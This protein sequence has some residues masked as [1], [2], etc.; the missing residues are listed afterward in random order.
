MLKTVHL[1]PELSLH[2][3]KMLKK[4]SKEEWDK[5]TCLPGRTV[6][7]LA[8]H[9][10]DASNL[11]RLSMQRDNYFGENPQINSYSDLVSFIQKL[12]NEWII[13]TKRLSPQIIITLL[14]NAE[15]ENYDF[16]SS[17]D[18]Y[19]SALFEVAWAGEEESYN[20]FDIAREYTEKWHH[21]MQIRETIGN[22]S[23]IFTPKFVKPVY[24]TFMKALPFVYKNVLAENNS[25]VV[26]HI[27]GICG[28]TW[29]LLR[30]KNK[31][32]LSD[33]IN[34]Q[35]KTE[36]TIKDNI[37]WKLFTNSIRKDKSSYLKIK[38]NIELGIKIADM[39]TVLS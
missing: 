33:E 37:A 28:G 25:L 34:G 21:Q 22:K 24:D 6:K 19:K 11:R 14:E 31:W 12:A 13:A 27:E 32:E 16:M 8:S 39:V 35:V 20:W 7:D 1:F 18:P 5:P 29:Y 26:F 10:L 3:I 4:L 36:V 38:G 2:L 9:I 17:L 30:N 15:K 23:E